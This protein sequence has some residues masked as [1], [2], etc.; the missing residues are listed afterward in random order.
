MRAVFGGE[1]KDF[2]AVFLSLAIK[3]PLIRNNIIEAL[4]L[5]HYNQ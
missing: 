5:S 2:L 3:I 1:V 4:D